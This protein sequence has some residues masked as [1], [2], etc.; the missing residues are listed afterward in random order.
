MEEILRRLGAAGIRVVREVELPR[1]VVFERGGFAALVERRAGGFGNV[2]G[3]GK[4]LPTG[5]GVLVWRG[6]Q[7]YFRTRMEETPAAAEE[8]EALRGFAADLEAALGAKG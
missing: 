5:F 8:V 4:L 6:S 2:G 1:H 7:A 3:A